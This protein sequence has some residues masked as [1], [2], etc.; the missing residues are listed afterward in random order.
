M[1]TSFRKPL[2]LLIIT[3]V[4]LAVVVL[5]QISIGPVWTLLIVLAL[6]TAE[7]VFVKRKAISDSS[8]SD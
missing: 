2:A 4:C 6:A 8:S 1:K 5:S 3:I 7:I